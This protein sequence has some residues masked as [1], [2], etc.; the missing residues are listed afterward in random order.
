MKMK[1]KIAVIILGAGRG[2]RLSSSVPKVLHKIAHRT[3]LEYALILVGK[4]RKK[5]G[6]IYSVTVVTSADLELKPEFLDL[7]SRYKFD[8]ARQERQWGTG[9]AVKTGLTK[10]KEETHVLVLYG[11]TPFITV[12]TVCSMV[13]QVSYQVVCAGFECPGP[14]NRYAHYGRI[15]TLSDDQ[16][17]VLTVVEAKEC[18]GELPNLCNTGI[19]FAERDILSIF[20]DTQKSFL[21][22]AGKEFHLTEVVKFA[23]DLK[24]RCTYVDIEE[25][26]AFGVNDSRQKAIAE[27]MMQKVLRDGFLDRGVTL[28]APDTVFFAAD[29]TIGYDCVIHPYVSIG[30]GVIMNNS[31]E[32]HSFSHIAG[33][34]IGNNVS[35][36]PFARIR[37]QTWI[38]DNTN[39]GNFSELKNARLSINVKCG[40]VSYIGDA[41]IGSGTNIGAG[42]VFCN[43]DGQTKH[44]TKVGR[45]VFI[46][47]N[48]SI[49]SPVNIGTDVFIAAGSTVVKSV[50]NEDLVIA[51]AEQVNIPKK[52]K[53]TLEE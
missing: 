7:Q 23:N 48:T 38:G 51:R 37:P 15:T 34:E 46:G 31:C 50:E 11:D 39:V 19:L 35:I 2:S 30:A 40:H 33:A 36:G 3:L 10:V 32:V 28:V 13:R 44:R 8:T 21:Q 29:T 17:K 49:V 12:D 25:S 6:N 27:C 5:L 53:R 24:K 22:S 20:C 1:M 14:D 18:Q 42:T 41:S 4:L 26:E 43:Y 45:N 52:G 47:S 16:S 9:E